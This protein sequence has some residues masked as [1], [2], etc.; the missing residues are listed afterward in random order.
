MVWATPRSAPSKENLEFEHHPARNVAYTFT[1]DT[2]RKYRTPNVIY[3][4]VLEC[5]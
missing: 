3:M 5:G 2:H 4:A 1:L